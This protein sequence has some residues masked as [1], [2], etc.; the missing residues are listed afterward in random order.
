[1]LAQSNL[2]VPEFLAKEPACSTLGVVFLKFSTKLISVLLFCL[3]FIITG[4]ARF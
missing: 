1:M 3:L 4:I 2:A